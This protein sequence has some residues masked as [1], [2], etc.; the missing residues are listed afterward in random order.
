MKTL[1]IAIP[2]LMAAAQL[3][4]WAGPYS[5]VPVSAGPESAETRPDD[6]ARGAVQYL[7]RVMDQFHS[8]LFVYDDFLSA[9]NHF[10]ERG[11]MC[12]PGDEDSLPPMDEACSANPHSG[13]T[14]IKCAFKSKG[15]NWGGWFFLNGALRSKGA[16]PE[17]NWGDV[18]NAGV[19]LQGS[20][21]LTFWARG[22]KGGERVKFFAFGLGRSAYGGKAS[23][24]YPDSSAQRSTGFVTLSR[25]WQSF[26][27]DT[28]GT[29]LTNVLL[30][31]A[32]QTKA[33]INDHKDI[34]FYL[35]D[36]AYD[37]PRLGDP[38][39]LV[40]Y[41][42]LNSGD[43][44][45][46]LLRNVAFTYDNAAA[47]LAFLAAG[48]LGR[49]RLIADAL[50]YVQNHDRY[51]SDGRIRNAY[52]G[53]DLSLARGWMPNGKSGSA[54]LPGWWDAAERSWRED[55]NMVGSSA[56]NMA[57]AMLA[58][59]SYYEVCGGEEYLAAAQKM[60]EWIE[61]NCCDARGAGGYT[62]GRE[63]WEPSPT[64]LTYK[65]T[66]HNL[67]LYAAF[68]RLHELTRNPVWHCRA[69]HARRFVRAMWDGQ[70]G[71]FWTGTG[72]DGATI[73]REVV[74]LDVQAWALLA[75]KE[76]GLSYVKGLR[77]A[78]ARC[79]DGAG[80]HFNADSDGV[81]FEGTAHMALAYSQAQQP[82]KR[83][84]VLAFLLSAQDV[85]GGLAAADRDAI[86]TGFYLQD[87]T[88]WLYY[89]RL[90]V[91]A[92]AW[93]VL[94]ATNTNPFWFGRHEAGA[95]MVAQR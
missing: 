64:K 62:A 3:N 22:E 40:S 26:T 59:L 73:F 60:G 2:V 53:G 17:L 35:D 86:S 90:H 33:T 5:R 37:K 1:N 14:C 39:L 78:Q 79:S 80:Y 89:R 63:G 54:R 70:E 82:D 52:Q 30:G 41:R 42:T 71:K 9:G 24:P 25:D 23:T 92:T 58:L 27:V 50:V 84:A 21:R 15:A 88:P 87:G 45:D 67:D 51:Y 32:W 16:S 69:E 36:I 20:T 47:L 93:L 43:D 31:F 28:S 19:D 72:D 38:R 56:G 76:R 65:S 49:A 77:Y 83:N 12:N 68:E 95:L 61:K 66:E 75:L 11:L 85:S 57:W 7:A 91:G 4:A 8:C 81:W 44:F 18:P 48:E 6:P 34:T 94:A 74:P 55:R 10:P 13:L 46:T 29:D